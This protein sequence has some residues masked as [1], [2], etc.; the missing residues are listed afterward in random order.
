MFQCNL[1]QFL[2]AARVKKR[3][4]ERELRFLLRKKPPYLGYRLHLSDIH[5]I[6]II[7]QI[8]ADRGYSGSNNL[9]FVSFDRERPQTR[10]R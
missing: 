10:L 7:S 1:S 5:H 8:A 2:L 3:K 9:S 6:A 4:K